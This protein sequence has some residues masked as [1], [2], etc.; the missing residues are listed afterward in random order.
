[1]SSRILVNP[2]SPPPRLTV[3]DSSATVQGVSLEHIDAGSCAGRD[4]GSAAARPFENLYCSNCLC[5]K[6]FL[7]LGSHLVC[8]YCAKRVERIGP[9]AERLHT[10]SATQSPVR[11][12]G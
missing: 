4:E 5:T 9:T 12:A 10:L 1:M 8:E 11:W 7:D 2:V 6:R 3:A